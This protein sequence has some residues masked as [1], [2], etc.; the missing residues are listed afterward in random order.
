MSE[1]YIPVISTTNKSSKKDYRAG[2]RNKYA[3]FPQQESS[4]IS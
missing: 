3:F 2:N 1:P 4:E